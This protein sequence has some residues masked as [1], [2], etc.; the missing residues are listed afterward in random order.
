M[1]VIIISTL[2]ISLVISK[3]II[4]SKSILVIIITIVLCSITSLFIIKSVIVEYNN[5]Y[6]DLKIYPDKGFIFK[7]EE[8]S[9]QGEDFY[10]ELSLMVININ[11]DEFKK[12]KEN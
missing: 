2:I 11:L 10:N 4:V 1:S 9:Y 6:D 12:I 3:S 8:V 5:K 7:K